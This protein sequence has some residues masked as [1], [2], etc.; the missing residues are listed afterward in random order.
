MQS[1]AVKKGMVSLKTS[2]G[3]SFIK[4]ATAILNRVK[5]WQ[6]LKLIDV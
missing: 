6:F 5:E 2:R 1:V 4:K 3:A